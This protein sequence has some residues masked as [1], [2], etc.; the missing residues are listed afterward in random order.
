MAR[1]YNNALCVIDATGIGDP[2][3]DDLMRAGLNVQPV[4][5][6]SETKKEIIEKLSIWI[7]QRI[8]RILNIPDTI[9]EFKN[10]TYDISSTGRVR[11]EAPAGFNDDIVI[12]H[13]LAINAL[14]PIIIQPKSKPKTLIQSGYEKAKENYFGEQA[15]N[16]DEWSQF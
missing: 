1:H 12:S 2:I 7:E 11:Y 13:G 5:L 8:I 3:C 9:R 14:N 6:T 10:F 4:K 16:L 15:G